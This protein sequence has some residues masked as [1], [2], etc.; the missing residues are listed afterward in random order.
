MSQDRLRVLLI[1]DNDDHAEL[2]QRQLQR[3]GGRKLSIR[4]ENRLKKGIE[5]L[6]SDEY[7]V[8][9]LD[10]MLPDSDGVET[11][12]RVSDCAPSVPIVV[13]TSLD[14]AAEAIRTVRERADD[15]ILK[16]RIDGELILRAV[17]LAAERGRRRQVEFVLQQDAQ[18]MLAARAVQVNLLPKEPPVVP[19]FDIQV[20][21]YPAQ[22]VGSDYYDFVP[23][24]D[25]QLGVAIGDASG[26]GPHA[27]LIMSLATG[28]IRTLAPMFDRLAEKLQAI[29]DVL[30]RSVS[31]GF[32]MGL[33]LARLDPQQRTLFYASAGHPL[34][35]VFDGSGALKTRLDKA[36]VVLGVVP[37]AEF[38]E[39]KPIQLQPGDVVL[40][41]TDGILEALS[42]SGESFGEER[43][44]QVMR[45][46]CEGSA[47]D[48]LAALH[49]E[50]TEFQAG[51]T[52]RDDFTG[53]AIKFV[54]ERSR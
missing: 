25:G 38:V 23:L 6:A 28:C 50:M 4:W 41:V 11:C 18:Q 17:Q 1:E 37:D 27:A 33:L 8:V 54:G 15:I 10:L 19:G 51:P 31:N 40:M 32:F 2:I 34:G 52:A 43:V 24:D 47:R 42:P 44:F 49:D 21:S 3:A 13:L 7:D 5:C 48:I 20:A 46:C 12:H 16:D 14:L 30:V 45:A 9:L 29:N 53:I 35:Y 26:H 22:M 39:G 36:S